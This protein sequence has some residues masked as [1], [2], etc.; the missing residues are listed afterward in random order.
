MEFIS[1]LDKDLISPSNTP[2]NDFANLDLGEETKE[3][4]VE[5][6]TQI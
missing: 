5:S 3:S 6:K 1:T 4:K 2:R